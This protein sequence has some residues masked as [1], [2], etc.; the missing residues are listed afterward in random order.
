[1]DFDPTPY[2]VS[3]GL[4]AWLK[5]FGVVGVIAILLGLVGSFVSGGDRGGDLFS[6]GFL[7]FFKELFSLSP[8]RIYALTMLTLK[9]ALR[10]RALVVFV[11]FAMLL[12]FGGWFLA[13][14]NNRADLQRSVHVTFM[15]T[16]IS[17]LI[18]PV[19][20]FL[21][22]WGIPEDIR[23]R[24]LHTVVTKPVRRVE[25]VIGRILGFS[26]MSTVI[27]LLMAII[28]Y[29]WIV[30]QYPTVVDEDGQTYDPLAC[31]VPHY[32]QLYFINQNGLP[33]SHGINVGDPWMY[34]SFVQGNS[35]SR[36]VWQ[37]HDVTAERL[38]NELRLESRFEAFRTIKGSDESI[39]GGLEAQYSLVKNLREEAFS[40]LGVGAS[41][42]PVADALREGNFLNAADLLESIADRME[43]SASDFPEIDCRQVSFACRIQTVP[44]FKELMGEEFAEV[45]KAFELLGQK[46][47]PTDG[48]A[49]KPIVY[50]E[51]A[52]A[53]RELSEVIR[54]RA[55]DLLESMPAIEVQLE[56]F[57]ISEY[58][59]G[60][61]FNTYPREVE[62][63][64]DY[65]A[66]A[67]FLAEVIERWN[68]EKKLISGDALSPTL[69]EDLAEAETIS[70][71]N[72]EL[73][74]DVLQ[75]EIDD[76]AL[77]IADGSLSV[78][79]GSRW[80]PWFFRTVRE[81]KL[82]S[83]DPAGWMLK[84]DIFDDLTTKDAL[85]VNVACLDDQMYL[86]MARADLFIRLHDVSFV[87]GYSK[88]ILN[89]GLMLALVVVLGVTAST[90][91]KGPVSFFFTLTV[92]VIGQFFHELMLKIIA[93]DSEGGGFLESAIMIYQHRNPNVGMDAS[94]STQ[95]AV[96]QVDN[97]L[98]G[99]LGG[100]SRIIPDFSVFSDAAA[101]I[102][103]G[104]DVPWNS[105]VLPS[106]MT[107][108]GFLVPCIIIGAA[109]LKFRELEAK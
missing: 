20:M 86:G 69:A 28:G 9:E 29:I 91:V 57:Q 60:D 63:S 34:R 1:M 104:F 73:L 56:P 18:L 67:R 4:I 98:K 51:L 27:L 40:T 82:I 95:Q 13:D 12:M 10:R 6:T 53:C 46:A 36:A 94:E 37:F 85:R 70:Q 102:E 74:V 72:A 105:S 77:S 39:E 14:S 83:L 80:L 92:F 16:T 2:N 22:C 99:F 35:R 68:G 101:Y 93:P 30:R 19:A 24:S 108:L 41:F 38:G 61:D 44:I 88:A 31:R 59:E 100:A 43:T 76:G 79:D 71:I 25:I 106:I 90:V 50:D 33:V 97:A 26:V 15:L 103:N 87:V 62:F 47:G 17:W 3:A 42:R 7:S 107:F 11:V 48:K 84:A 21:S 32:G 81:E 78:A 96:G 64:A 52:R 58:H 8:R 5:I 65:E 23:V 89:I 109:C 55:D 75:A 45:S 54:D 66:Q 49:D